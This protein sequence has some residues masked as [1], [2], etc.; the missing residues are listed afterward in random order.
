MSPNPVFDAVASPQDLLDHPRQLKLLIQATLG[1]VG[2]NAPKIIRSNLRIVDEEIGGHGRNA[3]WGAVDR[4]L[5]AV[6]ASFRCANPDEFD[7]GEK[8]QFEDIFKL[9]ALCQ[10]TLDHADERDRDLSEIQVDETAT[11]EAIAKPVDS[12]EEAVAELSEAGLTEPSFDQNLEALIEMGREQQFAAP[13]GPDAVPEAI[14]TRKAWI[15]GALGISKETYNLLGSKV[16]I[17]GMPA[18][19]AAMQKLGEAIGWLMKLIH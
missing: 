10:G 1:A 16:W 3:S 14:S 4:M 6:E 12:I 5:R 15:M 7:D 11:G 17:T 18:V 13:A 2:Q 9:N 19:A 8:Q